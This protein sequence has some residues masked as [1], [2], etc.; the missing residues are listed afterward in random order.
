M[1]RNILYFNT[2]NHLLA[3]FKIHFFDQLF[4]NGDHVT[5]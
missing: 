4:L 5:Y 1:R 2:C 3:Q